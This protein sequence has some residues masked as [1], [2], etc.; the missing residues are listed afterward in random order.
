MCSAHVVSMTGI[1]FC[2]FSNK[3]QGIQDINP[4]AFLAFFYVYSE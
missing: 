1:I 4:N 3:R 2:I